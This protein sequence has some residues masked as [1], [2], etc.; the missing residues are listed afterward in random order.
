MVFI[1]LQGLVLPGVRL[2]TLSKGP[3]NSSLMSSLSKS[4]IGQNIQQPVWE[5]F[6]ACLGHCHTHP[7]AFLWL[8]GHL[9]LPHLPIHPHNVGVGRLFSLE[10]V[11]KD[12]K[13]IFWLGVESRFGLSITVSLRDLEL[14]LGLRA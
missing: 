10:A 6:G 4:L 12:Q 2:V 8:D 5:L 14:P 1:L 3:H 9:P 11:G 7:I 13:E